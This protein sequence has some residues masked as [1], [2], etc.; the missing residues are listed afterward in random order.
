MS[1]L[2][3]DVRA[4]LATFAAAVRSRDYPAAS[5]LFDERVVGFGTACFRA[6][7]LARLVN[8]QWMPIWSATTGFDFD[9][10]SAAAFV[11]DGQAAVAV[12]WH[13]TGFDASLQPFDRHGRAT[14]VLRDCTGRGWIAV[15][16]HFSLTPLR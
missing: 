5:R 16:S 6:E 12:T 3:D 4:W 8:E 9:Y 2:G 15:H 1:A 7:G 14:F 11:A 10:A 13:S